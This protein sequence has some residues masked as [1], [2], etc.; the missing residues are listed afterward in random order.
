MG[1]E[2]QP[3]SHR[4]PNRHQQQQSP[5]GGNT[6]T[7]LDQF[8][9]S[10]ERGRQQH[11]ESNQEIRVTEGFDGF[12]KCCSQP[13]MGDPEASMTRRR[14]GIALRD[15]SVFEDPV[16]DCQMHRQIIVGKGMGSDQRRDQQGEGE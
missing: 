16:A 12:E 1:P 2:H 7:A 9:K 15:L 10:A 14:E 3:S 13:L 4:Q 5:E 11:G 8:Q 6:K